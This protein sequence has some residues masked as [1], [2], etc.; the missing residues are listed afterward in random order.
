MT[1]EDLI[2]KL[3][4]TIV[5][6]KGGLER[7]I[8]GCYVSD[9]LSDVLGS[10]TKESI[11]VTQQNHKNVVAVALLKQLSCVVLVKDI[12][13]SEEVIAISNKEEI[14]ILSTPSETFEIVCKIYNLILR[15]NCK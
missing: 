8:Q 10:A 14:P 3:N 6:G 4:L 12:L 1:V 9:V 11:W 7:K 15:Q 5:S 2:D 13:P